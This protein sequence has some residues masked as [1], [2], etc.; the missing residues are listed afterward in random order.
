MVTAKD[1]SFLVSVFSG[2]SMDI[3]D[4]PSLLLGKERVQIRNDLA[5]EANFLIFDLGHSSRTLWN[6]TVDK[7]DGDIVDHFVSCW[8]P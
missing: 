6:S 2:L 3:T 4:T 1:C 8:R 7:T 5:I